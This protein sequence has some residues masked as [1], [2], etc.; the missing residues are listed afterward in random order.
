MSRRDKPGYDDSSPWKGVD[1]MTAA[2]DYLTLELARGR[3]AW[4]ALAAHVREK[5]RQTITQEGG[6]LVGVFSPQ[7]GFASNEATVLTRWPSGIREVPG[8]FALSEVVAHRHETLTPTVRPKDDQKLRSGG[9]Y[10][11]RWFTIDRERTAEFID[12]SNRAWG[13]FEGSYD[14]EIFGLFTADASEADRKTSAQRLLL[15]TWYRDHGVWEASREQAQDAKSLFA[16][17]HLLTRTTIGRSSLP[18]V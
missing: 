7:L 4:G 13:N 5:A 6:E 15:L 16:Q 3:A 17:R 1:A 8:A 10:V 14:T 9:I 12:L 2:Y 11:H 18:I